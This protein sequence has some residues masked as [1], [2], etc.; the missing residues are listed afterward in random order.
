M[1][2]PPLDQSDWV[3]SSTNR[4]D[5]DHRSTSRPVDRTKSLT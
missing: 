4:R 5:E 1:R 3:P 2:T